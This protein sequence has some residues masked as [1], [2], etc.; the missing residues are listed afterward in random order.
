MLAV[1]DLRFPHEIGDRIVAVM[2]NTQRNRQVISEA[3]EALA[4]GDPRPFVAAFADDSTW[5]FPGSWTWSG[6]WSP[7]TRIVE[8]LLRPLMAQ[9]ADR[10]TARADT[11][12]AEGDHVVV[13][14]HGGATTHAGERYDQT[15]CYVFRMRD[16]LIEEVVEHCDTALV[17]RVLR[18]LVP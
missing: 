16:G 14:A 6:S 8:E 13:Q 12:L 3:F 2:T 10:Y 7:K 1:R 18:P 9:F 4:E 17:E 5:T 11:V 15:Y